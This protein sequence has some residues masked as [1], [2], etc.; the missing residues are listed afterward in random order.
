M[1]TWADRWLQDDKVQKVVKDSKLLSKARSNM[2][3]VDRTEETCP[4][5]STIFTYY[6]IQVKL[7]PL[8]EENK[9]TSSPNE[10]LGQQPE[11]VCGSMEEYAKIVGKSMEV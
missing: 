3:V 11:N 2:K 10:E 5:S 4:I 9:P 7:R 8:V 6:P 1:A